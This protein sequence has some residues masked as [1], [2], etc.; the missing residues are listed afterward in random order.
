VISGVVNNR[1]EATVIVNVWSDSGRALSL[2][3]QPAFEQNVRFAD[4]TFSIRQYCS[5][6]IEWDGME[7]RAAVLQLQYENLV[8]TQLLAGRRFEADWTSGGELRI[9]PL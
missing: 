2:G 7:H 4:G 1:S 6:V 8:G 5:A 3:M 9:I